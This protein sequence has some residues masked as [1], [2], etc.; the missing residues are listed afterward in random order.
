[1]FEHETLNQDTHTEVQKQKAK[2]RQHA[3]QY[4]PSG[5]QRILACTKGACR[6][7]L[8]LLDNLQCCEVPAASPVYREGMQRMNGGNSCAVGGPFLKAQLEVASNLT[9][10]NPHGCIAWLNALICM[11]E[12]AH[13][14][15]LVLSTVSCLH[16]R[17]DSAYTYDTTARQNQQTQHP[18]KDCAS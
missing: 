16:S 14:S 9:Q 10:G 11:A 1:M 8:A 7:V 18:I 13:M 17:Q 12:L 6:L 15:N 2:H 4:T 5:V 3:T